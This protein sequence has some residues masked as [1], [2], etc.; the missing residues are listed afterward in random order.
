VGTP[1]QVYAEPADAWAA[2]LTG[3]ASLVPADGAAAAP[4][5]AVSVPADGAALD[6]V[7]PDWVAFDGPIP[8]TVEAVRYRGTHT[9][10]RLATPLGPLILRE[11][12]PPRWVSGDR[13]SCRI[14]RR[15]RMPAA[16]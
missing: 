13:T 1:T 5:A 6:L 3:P 4:G 8:V 14:E 16:R 7:R 11:P 2:E 10:Y 12:G 9:D 15:W